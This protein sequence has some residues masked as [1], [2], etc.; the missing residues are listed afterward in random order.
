VFPILHHASQLYQELGGRRALFA[1][2]RAAVCLA[3][4]RI[5]PGSRRRRR[6]CRRETAY[7]CPDL[8]FDPAPAISRRLALI[9]TERKACSLNRSSDPWRAIADA[10]GEV[11]S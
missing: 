8:A 3:R 9:T 7:E 2:P 10:R 1:S 5:T 4:S 11:T 6:V